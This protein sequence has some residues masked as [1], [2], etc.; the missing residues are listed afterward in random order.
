MKK[1]FALL[2]AAAM[3]STTVLSGCGGSK[4]SSAGAGDAGVVAEE[5]ITW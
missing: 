3:V 1:K 4:D 2:L 5:G